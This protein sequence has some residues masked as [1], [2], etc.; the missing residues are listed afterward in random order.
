MASQQTWLE[1]LKR[2]TGLDRAIAYTVLA[3]GLQIL[4]S[5]GTVLLIVHYLTPVEQGYYY[6]LL[7]LVSLQTIFELGFSFVILQLAAHETVHLAIHQDGRIEGDSVAHSRLAS[8]L[9]KTMR[10]YLLA[11][12]LMGSTLLPLGVVFF[13]RHSRMAGEVAWQG[14]WI[15]AVIA[16][17]GL[18]MLNPVFSFLEG[19]GQVRQVAGMRLGQG[20]V[21]IIV[22]WSMLIVHRGLYSPGAVNVAYFSVGLVFLWSRRRILLSLLRYPVKGHAIVWRTEVWPFQ[23]QIAI[24]FLCSYFTM[25]VFTP[26]LFAS[27]GPIE[28]GRMGMSMSI[29]GYLWAIVFAWMSTKATPFG[30]LIARKEFAA[31]DHLFFRTL[32]QSLAMLATVVVF[33]MVGLFLLQHAFPR[34]ATRM[35]S[36]QLFALLLL[37]AM[38]TFVVQ[39]FAIYLRAHRAEPFLWQSLAVAGLTCCSA[40]VLIPRWGTTGAV[41]TYFLCTGVIS[42]ASATTIFHTKREARNCASVEDLVGIQL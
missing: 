9:Q 37:T 7:S 3:R 35:V 17:V 8:A 33:C 1:R 27:R 11:S 15:I 25:Q 30:N 14:P 32:K 24:S 6:T 39:S 36:V 28:A 4:G 18:F 29:A 16:T 23:W 31:L 26:I 2:I 22:P 40:F 21:A 41:I 38:S 10:W 12:V 20:V 5:T 42:L 34:I 13:S 19:C